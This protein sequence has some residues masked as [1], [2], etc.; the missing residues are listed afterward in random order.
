MELINHI[1]LFKAIHIIG[2][3]AWFGGLFYLV[4]IFVYHAE[5]FSRPEEERNI[6]IPQ[7]SLME[8]RVYKII[9][10]PGM[11]I[12]WTFGV[13]LL[14][15]YGT[16]WLKVNGWMHIKLTLLILLTLYHLWCKIILK[17]LTQG[18]ESFSSFNFRLFNEVPTIF[19]VAIVLFA[20]YKNTLP[21]A[22]TFGG[23][24][25]FALVL[26]ALAKLYKAQRAGS[27]KE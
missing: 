11:M 20:V 22:K 4:R 6:L 19:L 8:S 15:A 21:I 24:A 18:Q 27:G 25:V 13:L 14:V 1:L 10:N 16:D 5:A 23:L 2:F 9:C 7:Y 17:K 26:F 3:V 12:T